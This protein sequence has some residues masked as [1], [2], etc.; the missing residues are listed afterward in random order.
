[1]VSRT[2]GKIMEVLGRA[3]IHNAHDFARAGNAQAW[4]SWNIW[5]PHAMAR[6]YYRA[7]LRFQRDGQW[8]TRT[9]LPEIGIS[10]EDKRTECVNAAQKWAE[11]RLGLS[12]EGWTSGP[13]RNTWQRT[14]VRMNVLTG[15]KGER[16]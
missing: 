9:F 10:P 5:H 7:I 1:M 8:Y 4:I 3:G 13:F 12:R 16:S 11:E 2:Q 6:H 14:D 15:L